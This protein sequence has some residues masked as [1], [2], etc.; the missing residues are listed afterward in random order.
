MNIII[1]GEKIKSKSFLD[2]SPSDGEELIIILND[3][4]PEGKR[5]DECKWTGSEV[6]EKTQSD[7]LLEYKKAL[8]ARLQDVITNNIGEIALEKGR[9][10]EQIKTQYDDIVTDSA[11]WT[12]IAEADTAWD[13]AMDWLG[14]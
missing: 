12:T 5:R 13:N 10:I 9:T 4:W 11:A 2:I 6:V 3:S 14:L 7:Y 1:E 8:K